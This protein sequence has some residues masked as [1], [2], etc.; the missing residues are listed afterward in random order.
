MEERKTVFKAITSGLRSKKSKKNLSPLPNEAV[1]INPE[2]VEYIASTQSRRDQSLS[3]W[4][5]QVLL[6]ALLLLVLNF[7]LFAI[8]WAR[9]EEASYSPDTFT[10][11]TLP[12]A[13]FF[14][15]AG[16]IMF[17]MTILERKLKHVYFVGL[18]FLGCVLMTALLPILESGNNVV[19][20][21]LVAASA[22]GLAVTLPLAYVLSRPDAQT[23]HRAVDLRWFMLLV[24]WNWLAVFIFILY[25]GAFRVTEGYVRNIVAALFLFLK[26]IIKQISKYIYKRLNNPDFLHAQLFYVDTLGACLLSVMY[27]LTGRVLDFFLLVLIDVLFNV[28]IVLSIVSE[29]TYVQKQLVMEVV[30]ALANYKDDITTAEAME[31]VT[32]VCFT[33]RLVEMCSKLFFCAI[34]ESLIPLA[35][36]I[37]N[38]LVY[39][40]PT[41]NSKY[42][43]FIGQ[44]S[45]SDG[46]GSAVA[47]SIVSSFFHLIIFVLL[48]LYVT[49]T[50]EL[51][52]WHVGFVLLARERLTFV[53][54]LLGL[55]LFFSLNF[56]VHAGT[57][58][59]FA[60]VYPSF[61]GC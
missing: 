39:A 55:C 30:R 28:N 7:L 20:F 14:Y 42:L 44:S 4:I 26:Y 34:T 8:P 50:T 57:D 49:Q 48:R 36:S 17:Y 22:L 59:T 13:S 18:S 41:C 6:T 53:F 60:F 3:K 21:F 54:L 2:L 1:G 43:T 24:C 25:A 47:A 61:D 38:G 56:V 27:V 5:Q 51:D 15:I 9:P 10:L 12:L 16:N 46:F 23:P 40:I 37:S 11:W 32:A 58:T 52:V 19:R 33:P 29:A 31:E 35:L 45:N